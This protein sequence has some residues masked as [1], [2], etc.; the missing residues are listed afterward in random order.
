MP[1]PKV[2]HLEIERALDLNRQSVP[3]RRQFKVT[4]RYF[5][6]QRIFRREQ[7]LCRTFPATRGP[8]LRFGIQPLPQ[9]ALPLLSTQ[10]QDV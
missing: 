9:N 8:F 3:A 7:R 5:G 1:L 2:G 10:R 4:R 6:N